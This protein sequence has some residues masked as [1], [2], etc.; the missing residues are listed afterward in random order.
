MRQN[1]QKSW[2]FR[3][4]CKIISCILATLC[5]ECKPSLTL[6]SVSTLL[7]PHLLGSAITK[8]YGV[9]YFSLGKVSDPF[10]SWNFERQEQDLAIGDSADLRKSSSLFKVLGHYFLAFL[11]HIDVVVFQ[12]QTVSFLLHGA[13]VCLHIFSWHGHII[14]C[15]THVFVGSDQEVLRKIFQKCWRMRSQCVPG[16]PFPPWKKAW[17]QGWFCFFGVMDSNPECSLNATTMRHRSWRYY[18]NDFLPT[19]LKG[20]LFWFIPCFRY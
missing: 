2:E 5:T 10:G 7:P 19:L 20:V 18:W 15:T 13:L 8:T 16:S 12:K 9:D 3:F 11:F 1:S 17:V 4:F 6:I 14:M